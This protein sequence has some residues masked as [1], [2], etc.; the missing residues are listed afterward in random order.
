MGEGNG[1]TLNS[2]WILHLLIL[3]PRCITYWIFLFLDC[4]DLQSTPVMP[5]AALPPQLGNCYSQQFQEHFGTCNNY[6]IRHLIKR[7]GI[8]R[9][10]T[11][12]WKILVTNSL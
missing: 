7:R 5:W 8:T 3:S 4:R 11:T 2:F 6:A 9:P 10:H 1:L 12:R